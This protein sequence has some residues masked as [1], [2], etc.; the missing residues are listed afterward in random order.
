MLRSRSVGA[1]IGRVTSIPLHVEIRREKAEGFSTIKIAVL[2][3][4]TLQ[5]SV[6]TLLLRYSRA[7]DV[8]EMYF[9]SVA[10]FFT[11]VIKVFVCLYMVFNE[12]HG[13][14]GGFRAL[15]KQVFNQP[16]DTLKVCIPAVM[17]TFQNNLFYCAASH[18]EAATFM[19]ISQSK[20]F[21]TAVFSIILM[22]RRLSGIQWFSLAV[23]TT[24]VCLVQM[25]TSTTKGRA[26]DEQNP[27]IG[28]VAALTACTISGFAGVYFEKILK[29]SAPVSIWMRNIQMSVFAIPSSFIAIWLTDGAAVR[30]KGLLYGFDGVVWL[31]SFWYCIGGL[32]VAICIKYAD[33]IA[34]NFATS[35][36]IIIATIASIYL[37]DFRPNMMFLLG[38]TLV[39]SSIFLYSSKGFTTKTRKVDE[40]RV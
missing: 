1:D 31:T 16:W 23:L 13:P 38:G 10:V 5:N 12:S 18:L 17:Y 4:L 30:E 6:H 39:I 36:A 15:K 27:L 35:V 29:G 8:P 19:I 32:S 34:K 2:I 9:S 14:F 26:G 24:G 7:R 33:N 40:S 3:W 28:F 25:Q 37:F 21:T 20:I 22:N 11:E